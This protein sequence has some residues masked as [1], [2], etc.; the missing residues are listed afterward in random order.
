MKKLIL[1]AIIA[2]TIASCQKNYT[3]SCNETLYTQKDTITTK[4]ISQFKTNKRDIKNICK[5]YTYEDN[6]SFTKRVVTGCKIE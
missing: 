6:L 1:I 4:N 5:D 2:L 3:C